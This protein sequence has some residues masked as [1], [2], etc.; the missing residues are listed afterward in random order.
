MVRRR[1]SVGQI[2][3]KLR[4]ADVELGQGT[5]RLGICLADGRRSS[6]DV[7]QWD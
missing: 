1:H 5:K 6:R 4:Q 7:Q 2:I 3:G